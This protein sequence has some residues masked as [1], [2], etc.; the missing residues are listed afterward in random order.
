MSEKRWIGRRS[1]VPDAS[2]APSLRARSNGHCTLPGVGLRG[3]SRGDSLRDLFASSWL[4]PQHRDVTGTSGRSENAR[5]LQRT[6]LVASRRSAG[7]D[8]G[9]TQSLP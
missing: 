4:S 8:G 6:P 9:S 7:R 1:F 2:A 3:Y 5:R